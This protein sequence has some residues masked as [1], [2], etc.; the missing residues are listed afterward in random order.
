VVSSRTAGPEE[1]PRLWGIMAGF[2][3]GGSLPF[4]EKLFG[5][6]TDINLLELSD[7]SHPLLLDLM[8]MWTRSFWITAVLGSVLWGAL[9]YPVNLILLAPFLQPVE[10]HGQIMTLADVQGFEYVRAQT[11]EY[12][13]LIEQGSLRAFLREITAVVALSAGYLSIA[14]YL[15]GHLIGRYAL[16]PAKIFLKKI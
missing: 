5:I 2:L 13:R 7:V 3:M 15:F 10:Y 14:G 16:W 6:V 9:F 11:P 12:V 8:L 1:R 4:M